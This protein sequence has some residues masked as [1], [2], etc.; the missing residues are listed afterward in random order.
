MGRV[1][2]LLGLAVAFA[3]ADP[4]AVVADTSPRPLCVTGTARFEGTAPR[5][6]RVNVGVAANLPA[7]WQP[8]PALAI[9]DGRVRNVIVWV[10]KAPP[11]AKPL[12][13]PKP[14]PVVIR[15][16]EFNFRPRACAVSAG[17][18]VTFMNAADEYMSVHTLSEL[19]PGTNVCLKPA[20]SREVTY[21]SVEIVRVKSDLYP[22]MLAT[23][24]VAPTPWFAVTDEKGAFTL[25]DLVAGEY[26]VKAR[27]ETLGEL[28]KTVT[29]AAGREA[30]IEFV[31]HK[32]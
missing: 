22:W 10:A 30:A 25:K 23:V 31:F 26:V 18:K 2:A 11:G 3:V 17:S 19:N 4:P 9:A 28:E 12:Q 20:T 29:L 27:H 7:N 16:E 1:L 13:R 32:P 24:V 6:K 15:A 5:Q 14:A 21:D 8:D